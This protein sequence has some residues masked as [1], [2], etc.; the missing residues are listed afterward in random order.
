[1]QNRSNKKIAIIASSAMFVR[2][3]LAHQIHAL[4]QRY[5]VTVV[6]NLGESEAQEM[7]DCLPKSVKIWLFSA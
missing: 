4:S 7:L 6:V 5:S 3:F 2:V 1:M